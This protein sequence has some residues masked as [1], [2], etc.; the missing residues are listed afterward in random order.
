MRINRVYCAC[1][2]GRWG[3]ESSIEDRRDAA[4]VHLKEPLQPMFEKLKVK[5]G[6]KEHFGILLIFIGISFA[7]LGGVLAC[8]IASTVGA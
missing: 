6:P 7:V 3:S 1:I 2:Q 5:K 8:T 4:L